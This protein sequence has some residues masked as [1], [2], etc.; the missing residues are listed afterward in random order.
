MK[1]L[2]PLL[3]GWFWVVLLLLSFGSSPRTFEMLMLSLVWWHTPLIPVL[4]RISCEFKASLVSFGQARLQRD[5]VSKNIQSFRAKSTSVQQH[6]PPATHTHTHTHRTNEERDKS[7]HWNPLMVP[8]YPE[9]CEK[10]PRRCWC[11]SR[12]R[13]A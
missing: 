6:P 5:L 9:Y 12:E 13:Q 1:F 2:F 11:G 3:F 7:T 8:E 4:R 10:E